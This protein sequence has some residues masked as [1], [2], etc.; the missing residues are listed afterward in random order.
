[1]PWLT[2]VKLSKQKINSYDGKVLIL[3]VFQEENLPS[4]LQNI[5]NKNGSILSKAFKTKYFTGKTNTALTLVANQDNLDFII[6]SGLGKKDECGFEEIRIAVGRAIKNIQKLKVSKAALD[7]SFINEVDLNLSKI[8]RYTAYAAVM[9][10]YNF[11]YYNQKKKK[12]YISFDL[13]EILHSGN[14]D[15]WQNGINTGLAI[16]EGSC[17]ARDLGNHP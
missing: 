6:L 2:N 7:T 14:L 8:A 11:L 15:L 4:I 1:M 12:D 5:D 13:L 17:L 10:S 3:P 16:A 9:A